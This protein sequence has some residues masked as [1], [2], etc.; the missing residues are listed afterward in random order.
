MRLAEDLR[1]ARNQA[2]ADALSGSTATIYTAPMPATKGGAITTQT[3]L[4]SQSLPSGLASVNGSLTLNLPPPV[5]LA[6]GTAAW[7]RITRANGTLVAEDVCGL[8]DSSALFRL[9]SLTIE[10]GTELRPLLSVLTEPD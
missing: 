7:G 2:L 10:A 4:V 3:A 5:V 6:A 9:K 8:P 1:T